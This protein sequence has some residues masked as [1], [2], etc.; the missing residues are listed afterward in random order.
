MKFICDAPGD[1]TWFRLE[2]LDEAAAESASMHHAV[3]KYFRNETMKATQS[4]RPA[5]SSY[6]EQEIG[7]KAHLMQEMPIFLTL[8]DSEGTALA[9]AMLAPGGAESMGFRSIIVGPANGDP[10]PT[11]GDAITALARHFGIALER[12]RCFPYARN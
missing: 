12:D 9:T 1:R 4:F 8:R 7:L 11:Q 10:Y 2:T 3:E 6:V 5:S